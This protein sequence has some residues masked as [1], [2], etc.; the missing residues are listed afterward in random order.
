MSSQNSGDQAAAAQDEEFNL[1]PSIFLPFS[2]FP[3][4]PSIS[5]TLEPPEKLKK[6]IENVTSQQERVRGNMMF[7]VQQRAARLTSK[8]AEA[9][10]AAEFNDEDED[11]GAD[12]G[13]KQR[14]K[15][16][17]KEERQRSVDACFAAMRVPAKKGAR[18]EDYEKKID[19]TSSS[20]SGIGGN[21]GDRDVEMGGTEETPRIPQNGDINNSLTKI[22]ILTPLSHELKTLV[23]R[24]TAEM[25]GYDIHAKQ[26]V[27]HY[28]QALD[29][30]TVKRGS[31]QGVGSMGSPA[32][33][34][35][36]GG[37]ASPVDLHLQNFRRMST[38]MP[39]G[40]TGSSGS[41]GQQPTRVP[42]TIE[43]LTRR[44]SK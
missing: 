39:M 43:E 40:G 34:L 28:Q 1:A 24:G 33:A 35:G 22:Q 27:Q 21:G 37:V 25:Q 30:R 20:S 18:N 19:T 7:L 15:D 41:G 13:K 2:S 31:A 11:G 6:I 17:K 42:E 29:R 32:N 14:A 36:G 38:G 5:N 8:A 12:G 26:V 3:P 10:A 16:R 4:G 44:G 9:C 23:D